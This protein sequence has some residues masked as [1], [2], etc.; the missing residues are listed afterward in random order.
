MAGA[1]SMAIGPS[2]RLVVPR[3]VVS[4]AVGGSTVLLNSQTGRYFTLDDV[5][6]RVWAAVT[7]TASMQAA[8][9]RL[10]AEFAADPDHVRADVEHLIAALATRGLIEIQ[11]A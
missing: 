5:G 1:L 8:C 6:G 10:L 11:R 2:D 3:G 7:T 4:R 9:D